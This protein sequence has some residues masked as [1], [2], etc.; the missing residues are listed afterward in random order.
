MRRVCVFCGSSPGARPEYAAAAVELGALLAQRG[1]GVVYGGATVGLMGLL[2]DSAVAA[3][4][5]V[6]G[7]IPR[8]IFP[9]EIPH[10]G[11][12]EQHVVGSMHER[13]ALMAELSDGFISLPGGTGTL[14]ELF[15]VFTWSQL[16]IHAKG[17]V[18][19]NVAGYWDGL[20]AF[21]DHVVRERF[22]RPEH[23]AL[24]RTAQ[25]GPE[26]IALLEAFRAPATGKWFD[27]PSP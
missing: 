17:S 27:R 13:K 24:M 5:E 26:A 14:E 4:G 20:D 6:H 12:T 11:L 25:T 9:R 15:E 1:I 21:L 3:G 8:G 18:L 19:L 2:A 22:L 16:G 10:A 7:V 23:R